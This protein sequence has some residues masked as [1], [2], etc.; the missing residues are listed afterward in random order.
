ML[1][2]IL[3][4]AEKKL[5]LFFSFDQRKYIVFYLVYAI[6]TLS[7]PTMHKDSFRRPG[8]LRVFPVFDESCFYHRQLAPSHTT[9][10]LAEI[11]DLPRES[12]IT[13][14]RSISRAEANIFLTEAESQSLAPCR[15]PGPRW[16]LRSF[17]STLRKHQRE[18]MFR[19]VYETPRKKLFSTRIDIVTHP[20]ESIMQLSHSC[21]GEEAEH[22]VHVCPMRSRLLTLPV[23]CHVHYANVLLGW[24]P[25]FSVGGL[26]E[27][28]SN[29]KFWYSVLTSRVA[30]AYY[31]ILCLHFLLFFWI[32]VIS[33]LLNVQH[34]T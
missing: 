33:D 31:L 16:W 12:A 13:P 14:S 4:K 15:F 18:R 19:K 22:P 1:L 30:Q 20:Q 29:P 27:Q 6:Y 32:L 25:S 10:D 21:D 7:M 34:P 3:K 26:Y 28:M 11:P 17:T 9:E 2:C 23:W 8:P 5:P 24:L